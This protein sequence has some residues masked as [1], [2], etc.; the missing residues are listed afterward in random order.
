MHISL[1]LGVSDCTLLL[2]YSGGSDRSIFLSP[3]PLSPRY[4]ACQTHVTHIHARQISSAF[5]RQMCRYELPISTLRHCFHFLWAFFF[6]SSLTVCT[7][8]MNQVLGI[9]DYFLFLFKKQPD[10]YNNITAVAGD[11]GQGFYTVHSLFAL[12][13]SFTITIRCNDPHLRIHK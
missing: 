1:F 9:T 2:Q 8:F 6:C 7:S 10:K 5:F 13:S 3:P 4:L 12:Q 11:S